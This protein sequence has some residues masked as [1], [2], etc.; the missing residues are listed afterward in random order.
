M[1]RVY[2]DGSTTPIS[3]NESYSN[4]FSFYETLNNVDL[5]DR[6]TQRRFYLKS[7]D[8]TDSYI[9]CVLSSIDTTGTS[10]TSW[11]SFA[12]D[13]DGAAGVYDSYIA[14][15]LGEGESFYF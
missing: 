6:Y 2:K 4:P 1:I 14:F 7:V 15:D 8:L 5:R 12:I 13:N 10:E 11:L 9:D 3:S